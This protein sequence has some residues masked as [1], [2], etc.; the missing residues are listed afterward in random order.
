MRYD[1][2]VHAYALM[3]NRVHLLLTPQAEDSLTLLMQHVCRH[4][5]PYTNRRNCRSGSLWEG[6]YKTSLVQQEVY[7]FHCYH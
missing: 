4:S 6:R 2:T 7:L 3:T 5:V 1:C